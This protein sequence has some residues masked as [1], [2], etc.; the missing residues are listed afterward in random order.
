MKVSYKDSP[1]VEKGSHGIVNVMKLSKTLCLS[2]IVGSSY[3]LVKSTHA[4][5]GIDAFIK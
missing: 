1:E 2:Q 3:I 5:G 4:V